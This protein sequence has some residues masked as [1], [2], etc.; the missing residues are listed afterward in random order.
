MN[1]LEMTIQFR[2]SDYEKG[3]AWYEKWLGRPADFIPHEDFAEWEVVSGCWLQ[4][5]KG[6]P[7]EASGPL[8]LGVNDIEKERQRLISEFELEPSPIGSRK[9]V[10]VKWCTFSDPWG[11]RLGYFEELKEG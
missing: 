3:A 7:A 8:R 5:A 1:V 10:P 11:N 4:I 2:V 9:G 6:M